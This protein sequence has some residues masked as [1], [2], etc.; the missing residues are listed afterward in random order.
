[1]FNSISDAKTFLFNHGMIDFIDLDHEAEI[2]EDL[3]RNA[4]DAD[5]AEVIINSYVI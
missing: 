5:S 1:M 4:T 2:V 3:Y